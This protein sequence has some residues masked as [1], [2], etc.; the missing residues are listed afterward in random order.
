[1]EYPL[2]IKEITSQKIVLK[3]DA[4][5]LIYLPKDKLPEDL[6]IGQVINLRIDFNHTDQKNDLAKEILNELLE[7]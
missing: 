2:T 5:N 6:V 1:M 4:D 3:D 7:K